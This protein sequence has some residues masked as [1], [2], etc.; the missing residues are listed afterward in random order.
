MET[1]RVRVRRTLEVAREGLEVDWNFTGDQF[2]TFKAFFEQQLENGSLSFV[3]EVMDLGREVEFRD[4]SYRFNH[5]DSVYSVS[6][7]L[8]MAPLEESLV[9]F[10]AFVDPE[11]GGAFIDPETGGAFIDPEM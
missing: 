5:T 1:G 11:L 6:A 4:S 2:E 8:L 7:E 3:M 9:P 10:G